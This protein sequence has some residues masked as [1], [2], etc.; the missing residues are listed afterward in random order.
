MKNS[1]QRLLGKCSKEKASGQASSTKSN[2]T[3]ENTI[4]LSN[5]HRAIVEVALFIFSD[6]L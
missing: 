6:S 2:T 5:C 4:N 1:S 3:C